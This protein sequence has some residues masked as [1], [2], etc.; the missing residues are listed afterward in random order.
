MSNGF[1]RRLQFIGVFSFFI[2]FSLFGQAA[3]SDAKDVRIGIVDIQAAVSGTKEWKR[4]FTSFKTKFEKEKMLIS[5]REKK[6]KKMIADL[7]KQSMVLSPKLKKQKEDTLLKKKKDFERHVQDKNEE[8]AKKEKEITGKI[9][10]KMVQ[11]IRTLGETKNFTMILEK[12][13]ALY[14][15]KS[16]DLTMLATKTYDRKK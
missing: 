16:V 10:K 14:F 13:V 5:T 11:V 3:P 9:L 8:F 6:L 7:S 1:A 4:E 12:K 15:D 2:T